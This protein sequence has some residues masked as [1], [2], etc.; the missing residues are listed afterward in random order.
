MTYFVHVHVHVRRLHVYVNDSKSP[1]KPYPPF[2]ASLLRLSTRHEAITYMYNSSII[3]TGQM[4]YLS[5]LDPSIYTHG[6]HHC[7][8]QSM[9]MCTVCMYVYMWV[10]VHL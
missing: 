4:L 9:Y 5:L 6:L 10:I 2:T 8:M 1:P 7:M 3:R